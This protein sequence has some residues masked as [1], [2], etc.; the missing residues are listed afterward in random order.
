[1]DGLRPAENFLEERRH[2]FPR[3][4]VRQLVVGYAR[5]AHAVGVRIGEAVHRAAIAHDLP[6]RRRFG[7]LLRQSVDLR[8]WDKRMQTR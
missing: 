6:V 2:R 5:H 7:H 8:H 4:L 1:M 3:P